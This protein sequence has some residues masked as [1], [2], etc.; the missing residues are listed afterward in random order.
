[1]VSPKPQA[2]IGCPLYTTSAGFALPAGPPESAICFVGEALGRTEAQRSTPFVGEAGVYLNR[3]YSRLG[4]NRSQIRIGNVCSCQPPK[5]W[6]AGAPWEQ[7]AI[8]HCSVHRAALSGHAVYVTMGVTATRV[9]LK[10]LLGIDYAGKLEDW[11]GYVLGDG[12]Y[13]IPTFHPAYL[14]RGNHKLFGAFLYD[15]KRAMEVASFGLTRS[16]VDLV[17]DPPTD[18]FEEYVEE[19]LRDPEAWMAVDIETPYKQANEDDSVFMSTT[20]ILRVNFSVNENQGVTV[21]WQDRYLFLIRR[22]LGSENPKVFWNERF[23]IP[24]LE[25]ANATPKGTVLDGMWAWH[26][27]QSDL[28]K[29]LGF[30]SPF[31]SDMPPWKHLAQ[32]E[33]GLYAAQDAVQQLRNMIGIAKNLKQ[34]NQWG[35]FMKFAVKLDTNV[36]HPMEKEGILLHRDGLS[37]LQEELRLKRL[38]KDQ[39]IQDMVPAE[40]RPWAGGWKRQPDPKQWPGAVKRKVMEEVLV[41]TDC[42]ATEVGPAHKC[43]KGIA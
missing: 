25:A 35:T 39:E 21:P 8:R 36:L 15:I 17:V 11:H 18:W 12:P 22:L 37:V 14:L 33:P 29:G 24:I 5:D 23:D 42:G 9:M 27:L 40:V 28:P 7:A 31:Y 32:D 4:I 16:K 1:M 3:A 2:C 26:I 6:L 30:V 41:C 43:K 13:V 34:H 38:A 10:E 20:K 19:A